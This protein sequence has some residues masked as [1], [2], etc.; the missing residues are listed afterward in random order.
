MQMA[1][2]YTDILVMP[3]LFGAIAN[4]ISPALFPFFLL[5]ILAPMI[6]SHEHMLKQRSL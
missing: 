3:T 1:F 2:A 5:L 4:S 6:L